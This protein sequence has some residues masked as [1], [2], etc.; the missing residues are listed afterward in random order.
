[1]IR[2]PGPPLLPLN[3]VTA[4][5][6]NRAAVLEAIQRA[7]SASRA[8]LSQV[9]GLTPATISNVVRDLVEWRLVQATGELAPR[10]K[11]VA[12]APSPLLGLDSSWHRVLSVHQGVSRVLL[13][14][15]DLAG[16]VLASIELPARPGESPEGLIGRV[17]EGL[18]ALVA[19]QGWTPEQVRGVGVGAV[20]LVDPDT[21][22]VR[23][24]P[25]L[26][27]TD[28]PL[29]ERLESSLDWPVVV[30]NNVHAMAVGECRFAGVPERHAVY[31]Y[32]GTGIGSGIIAESRVQGGAHGAAGELGHL[33]VPGGGPCSCGKTGCL[34]TVAA[35]PAIARRAAL[36][37]AP[38]AAV[39]RVVR[40]AADGDD[41]ATGLLRDVAGSL[42]LA[43]A[44]VTE[45][46]NPGAIIVNGIAAE[47][48]DV[49]L[50]PLARSLRR[51]TFAARGREVVVRAAAFGR[52]AG[53]VGAAA[54]ALES[55]VYNPGAEVFAERGGRPA[56][57]A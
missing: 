29:R 20:G 26:G 1:M 44:Q 24:A 34:E 57:A 10:R 21:G 13:G 14:G 18:R 38:K 15:H 19:E 4:A 22:S 48:G 47:A 30:R 45:V 6:Q 9:T 8:H 5:R 23:A 46:L 37:G 7:G 51:N 32:V 33:V 17:M 28:V 31:V 53:I 11:A 54:L 49:F 40:Q 55:F 56:W 50:A 25:N 27:W 3:A 12:G 2:R 36:K 43:M 41:A 35:E 39:E 52:Q 16:G 42:G